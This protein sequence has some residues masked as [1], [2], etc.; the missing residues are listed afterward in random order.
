MLLVD[1]VAV[2]LCTVA[3]V[4]A[5]ALVRPWGRRFPR[6]LLLVGAWGTGAVLVVH[7]VPTV[8]DWVALAAG[9][10][11]PGDLTATEGF[12]TFLYEPFFLAGGVLYVLAALCFQL[13]V[14]RSAAGS[15][16]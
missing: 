7:A 2:P 4:L 8:P 14:D 15:V 9:R 10:L 5:L 12:V 13:G 1:V 11:A 6:R 3:A 16:R